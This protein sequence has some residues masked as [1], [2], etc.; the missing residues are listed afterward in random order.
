M[1]SVIGVLREVTRRLTHADGISIVLRDGDECHYVEEDAIAPLWKGQRIPMTNCISGWCMIHARQIAIADITTDPRVPQAA[2]AGTFVKSLAMAPIRQ[3]EPIGALGAYWAVHHQA[4]QQELDVL[5]ALGDSAAMALANIRLIEQMEQASRRKDEFLSM[6]AHE[7]RN[8]LAPLRN[9]LELIQ[10]NDGDR[11]ALDSARSMMQRQLKHL[12]RIID[13]LL[14]MARVR[15]GKI[16]LRPE[17]LDLVGIIRQSAEDRRGVLESSGLRLQVDVPQSPVYA[18]CDATRMT[19]VL[20]SLLD[21]ARKFTR[22]GG[23]ITLRLE[24]D[25]Q[26]R[27]ARV[28]ILDTGIGIPPELLARIFDVFEQ[29]DQKLDRAGGGL[30]LGLPLAKGLLELHG[31]SIH[32]VSRGIGHGAEFSFYLP[33]EQL[34]AAQENPPAPPSPTQ[35]PAL[36]VLVV[37]DNRDA[38]DSLRLLL[39]LSGYDAHVAYTGTAGRDAALQLRPQVI[40]CDIGLPEMDG[41]ALA[42][43]L[44]A[45]PETAAAT[46]IAVSGYGR[47][48]DRQRAVEAG[49]DAHLVKPVDFDKVLE[50]LSKIPAPSVVVG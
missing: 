47:Q 42:S 8:P 3:K 15:S 43:L 18:R 34:P 16:L 49:F 50:H 28:S 6:L 35:R 29:A 39:K 24:V 4:T 31:G 44:R 5:Q 9:A 33:C 26:R 46:I 7:L 22:A 41:Y 38:A 10:Q 14:D 30:G 21:N 23:E 27:R 25:S 36:R 32:A 20:D 37:E 1:P 17:R 45:A 12:A 48:E 40:L 19:Q 11:E 2:Y 13:D